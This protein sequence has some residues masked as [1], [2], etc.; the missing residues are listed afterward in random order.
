MFLLCSSRG[1]KPFHL[2]DKNKNWSRVSICFMVI[3]PYYLNIG[4][5]SWSEGVSTLNIIVMPKYVLCVVPL[6]ISFSINNISL[7]AEFRYLVCNDILISIETSYDVN[8]TETSGRRMKWQ[9]VLNSN[10]NFCLCVIIFRNQDMARKKIKN[11]LSKK[12]LMC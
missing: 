3:C 1:C 6:F 9:E 10:Q 2:W 4:M 5:T 12:L 8:R 11:V 7:K